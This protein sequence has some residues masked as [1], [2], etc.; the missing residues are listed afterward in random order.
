RHSSALQLTYGLRVEGT[1]FPSD[2]QY[3]PEVE[4]LFGRR[5]DRSPSEVHASPRIGFTY[6]ISAPDAPTDNERDNQ[7]GNDRTSNRPNDFN[8]FNQNNWIVRNNINKF[9]GHISS[10]LI[11]STIETTRLPNNQS[12]LTCINATIPTPN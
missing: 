7:D 10:N 5:T 6:F 12:T 11:A 4:T 9:H 1:R 8:K 2:P 3:N